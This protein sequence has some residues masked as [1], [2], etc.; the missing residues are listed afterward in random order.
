MDKS[1]WNEEEEG[2]ML[3]CALVLGFGFRHTDVSW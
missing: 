1:V 2:V 3:M